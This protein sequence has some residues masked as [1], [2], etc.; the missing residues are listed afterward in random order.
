MG[1]PGIASRVQEAAD[2]DRGSADEIRDMCARVTRGDMK[3]AAFVGGLLALSNVL[4]ECSEHLY[5]IAAKI[6]DDLS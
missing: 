1:E 2:A 4:V 3:V 5:H 6:P